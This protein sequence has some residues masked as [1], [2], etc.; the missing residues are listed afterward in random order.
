M[1][2]ILLV[3][4]LLSALAVPNHGNA[5]GIDVWGNTFVSFGMGANSYANDKYGLFSQF[6]PRAQVCLGKWL[7]ND[8]GVRASITGMQAHGGTGIASSYLLADAVF[9]F[10]PLRGFNRHYRVAPWNLYLYAGVGVWGRL[11]SEKVSSDRD[12]VGVAGLNGEYKLSKSLYLNLEMGAHVIPAGYDYNQ[13]PSSA[14]FTMLGL[15][16][17]IKDNPYRVPQQGESRRFGEDWYAGLAAGGGAWAHFSKGLSFYPEASVGIV[18]GKRMSVA[19]EIRARLSGDYCFV[20]D[21]FFRASATADLMCNVL[22]LLSPRGERIWNFSPYLG[23]GA[24]N[25]ISLETA[26]KFLFCIEGGLNVRRRLSG[27]SDLYFDMGS[28]LVPPRVSSIGTEIKATATIGWIYSLG[29]S[30]CR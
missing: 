17:K 28:M 9:M 8:M 18:F 20:D 4:T 21:A 1:K 27:N 24:I 19:W 12:F 25:D 6:G 5:R 7:F 14:I 16:Y 22:N 15:S 23:V 30:N 26:D 29:R 11:A 3:A 2:R 13:K 10:N